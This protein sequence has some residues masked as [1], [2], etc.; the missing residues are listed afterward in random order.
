MYGIDI[1]TIKQNNNKN[2]KVI[3]ISSHSPILTWRYG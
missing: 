3:L 1:L 2:E